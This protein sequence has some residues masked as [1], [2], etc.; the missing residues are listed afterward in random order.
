ML[1]SSGSCLNEHGINPYSLW[2][3]TVHEAFAIEHVKP[4]SNNQSCQSFHHAQR[5]TYSLTCLRKDT[6]GLDSTHISHVS[7]GQVPMKTISK[8]FKKK[9][10][11]PR[12][13]M[14]YM[15]V[16]RQKTS[17]FQKTFPTLPPL[18]IISDNSGICQAVSFISFDAVIITNGVG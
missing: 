1:F 11:I 4:A 6:P 8:M 13:C 14:I 17:F 16:S 15:N 2:N 10:V 9:G 18:K 7:Q 12:G 5:R 3:L